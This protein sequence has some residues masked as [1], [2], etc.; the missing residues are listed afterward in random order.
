[1][2]WF[3]I[4]P[5]FVFSPRNSD[6]MRLS[7]KNEFCAQGAVHDLAVRGNSLYAVVR[8]PF[9]NWP[10]SAFR[11]DD[12]GD[13]WR[14]ISDSADNLVL[15]FDCIAADPG[16]G[17][18]ILIGAAKVAKD[19][20]TTS[21]HSVLETT[22][23][24]LH[25]TTFPVAG[26]VIRMIFDP[27]NPSRVYAATE[28]G[29]LVSQNGGE[30][31]SNEKWSSAIV[32][33]SSLTAYFPLPFS[34]DPFKNQAHFF[35]GVPNFLTFGG[36][37]PIAG[38]GIYHT[39]DPVD[40]AWTRIFDDTIGGT[41]QYARAYV[42]FVPRTPQRLYARLTNDK[43]K[44]QGLFRGD[45][46]SPPPNLQ[47]TWTD[48]NVDQAKSD[49]KVMDFRSTVFG[50]SPNSAGDE[51]ATDVIFFGNLCVSRSGDGGQTWRWTATD[52]ATADP[53][54]VAYSDPLF[55]GG[56]QHRFAFLP[57]GET[58]IAVIYSGN[59][60]GLARNHRYCDPALPPPPNETSSDFQHPAQ[61]AYNYNEGLEEHSGSVVWENS[62]HG[63]QSS[64][65]AG[66]AS[67]PEI[68]ALGYLACQDT[69]V[70]GGAASLAS[71]RALMGGDIYII[72]A[73]AGTD[74]VNVWFARQGQHV[75]AARDVGELG[76]AEA[77]ETTFEGLSL[78]SSGNYVVLD[79]VCLAPCWVG[80]PAPLKTF[81]ASISASGDVTRLSQN[82]LDTVGQHPVRVAA[83][84][85]E[86]NLFCVTSDLDKPPI[87]SYYHTGNVPPKALYRLWTTTQAAIASPPAQ[88]TEITDGKPSGAIALSSIAIGADHAL[89]VLLTKGS[90]PTSALY[91]V[92]QSNGL[93]TWQAETID[94]PSGGPFA[95]ADGDFLRF[96][97]IV[98]HPL[99][100]DCLFVAY[101][102]FVYTLTRSL[103]QWTSDET[104]QGLPK[105]GVYDL[106]VGNV[107]TAK[108]PKILLRA[109]VPTR[110][111]WECDVTVG[112]PPQNVLYVRDNVL[113]MGWLSKSPDG[114][115]NPYH[116]DRH[117]RHFH[118]ADLKIDTKIFKED[119]AG[120]QTAD[121]PLSHVLFE[122]LRDNSGL[123]VEGRAARVHV[124][125]HYRGVTPPDKVS[126]WTIYCNAAAVVP[127]LDKVKDGPSFDFWQLFNENGT[128]VANELPAGSPWKS[129]G[130]PV[131][132]SGIH[133]AEPKVASWNWTIPSSS[134]DEPGHYC[135]VTFIHSKEHPIRNK[136]DL[137]NYDVD[138]QTPKSCQI[139][140]KNVHILDQTAFGPVSG[141]S[142]E[143]HNPTLE[144][145]EVTLELDFRGL[146]G[147]V[148]TRFVL[149]PL[150]TTAS[151]PR[152][153]SGVARMWR[154]SP[155]LEL[156]RWLAHLLRNVFRRSHRQR[157]FRRPGFGSTVY[158][159]APSSLVRIQGVR[160]PPR[161]MCA[162]V[163]T[164]DVPDDLPPGMEYPFEVRQVI[165]ENVVGGITYVLRIPGA[166]RSFR[167]VEPAGA[168]D[169]LAS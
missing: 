75:V 152:S 151:L 17:D 124:Q 53:E 82:F 67:D 90:A 2:N 165:D 104:A 12:R 41:M 159:A 70:A 134:G 97:K 164:L 145:R 108:K 161:G 103:D 105:C 63:M 30:I 7:R 21:D 10:T 115:P 127:A 118:C 126:V 44:T 146:P 65:V 140:Q 86:E 49:G 158:E 160:L 80:D 125:V 45:L 37:Q 74:G 150:D 47:W 87:K 135:V 148:N 66:Y 156:L 57:G 93:W 101:A 96:R 169:E 117:V 16:N 111:M 99:D 168:L 141:G 25:W 113:D 81:V 36:D 20:R 102:G 163:L 110:G 166:R 62:N 15:S 154:P 139:G 52:P 92:F 28:S 8:P 95:S 14:C 128:I 133:V 79:D 142:I 138:A 1:M 19:Y 35:A 39:T 23:G 58:E 50:V 38:G 26:R 4:G 162:A 94:P 89:Y 40:T 3:P 106:W 27:L 78:L 121:S 112:A 24:G 18:H 114:A 131:V 109:A 42:D 155:I 132:L 129:M 84:N 116:P 100:P 6:F 123:L 73:K 13:S 119:P 149:T 46:S 153:I 157:R 64:A 107:G 5:D 56:E 43:G 51:E 136:V 77:H 98:A 88:W 167:P 120:F 31:W 122:Q 83:N 22:D 11:S 48:L 61:A 147:S 54:N 33:V 32:P 34:P 143:F 55:Y 85:D 137:K 76:L 71:W 91:K 72:A 68:A 144:D 59:D 130:K 9:H 69:A 60:G 29:V